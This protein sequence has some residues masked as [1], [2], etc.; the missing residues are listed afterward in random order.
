MKVASKTHGLEIAFLL[1]GAIALIGTVGALN[2]GTALT[3]SVWDALVTEGKNWL[4]ST[5]TLTFAVL[6]LVVAVWQAGHGRGYGMLGMILGVLVIAL[7][8]PS[9][10]TSV[11]KSTRPIPVLSVETQQNA[12]ESKPLQNLNL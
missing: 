2:G 6:L 4:A 10:V 8:G 1:C 7:I 11:A 12:I 3:A 5:Y 9:V